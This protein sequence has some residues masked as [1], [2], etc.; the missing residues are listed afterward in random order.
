METVKVSEKVVELFPTIPLAEQ[1]FVCGGCG[2]REWWLC[3]DN[4]VECAS[5]HSPCASLQI[6]RTDGKPLAEAPQ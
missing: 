4:V 2:S 1:V 3:R 6:S 5:C